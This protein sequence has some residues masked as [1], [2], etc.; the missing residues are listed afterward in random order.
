MKNEDMIA[1]IKYGSVKTKRD[2]V[3]CFL[4]DGKQEFTSYGNLW[5]RGE[6]NYMRTLLLLPKIFGSLER[7]IY[8]KPNDELR[9]KIELST[10]FWK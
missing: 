3:K 6:E 2:K 9:K 4:E 10:A 8:V 1:L 7:R 5:P